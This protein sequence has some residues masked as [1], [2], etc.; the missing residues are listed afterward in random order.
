MRNAYLYE[1]RLYR[2]RVLW[3][4]SCEL[5]RELA[6]TAITTS[7]IFSIKFLTL[8]FWFREY[9]RNRFMVGAI[10]EMKGRTLT[11]TPVKILDL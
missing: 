7:Q 6:A 3:V 8:Q 4:V 10:A 5:L 1:K 9:C 11:I 2:F